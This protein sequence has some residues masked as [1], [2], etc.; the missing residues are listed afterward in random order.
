M[1]RRTFFGTVAGG[2]LAAPLAAG[3]QQAGKV[4]KLGYLDQGAAVSSKS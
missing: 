2:L 1:D 4:W 3:A